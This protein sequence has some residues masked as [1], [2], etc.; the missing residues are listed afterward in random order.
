V[1]KHRQCTKVAGWG[2]LIDKGGSG[3]NLGQDALTAYFCA[4][5]GTGDKTKLTEEIDVIYP[6]GVQEIMAYIYGEGKRAVA[7]FAPAVFAAME[8]DDAIAKE[9]FERN[10]REAV[11]IVETAAIGFTEEKIPL[12]LAGG[13]A[14][15]PCVSRRIKELL[16]DTN[17][18]EVQILDHAPVNGAVL[19]AKELMESQEGK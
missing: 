15:Q 6:G 7:S 19:L 8:K 10:I 14:N 11:H 2:Y 3:Y 18:F 13:L 16:H 17:R 12:V 1:Q 4:V 5:D 9:I